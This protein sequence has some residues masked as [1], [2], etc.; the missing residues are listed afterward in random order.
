MIII[1]GVSDHSYHKGKFCAIKITI[2]VFQLSEAMLPIYIDHWIGQDLSLLQTVKNTNSYQ[3][4]KIYSSKM[5]IDLTKSAK[6]KLLNNFNHNFLSKETST[7][8]GF[9][10]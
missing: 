3:N 9:H 4:I 10:Q 2:P 5:V 8:I 7:K 6:F 1:V